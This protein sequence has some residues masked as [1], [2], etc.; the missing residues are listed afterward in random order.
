MRHQ[1]QFTGR[2]NRTI[3]TVAKEEGVKLV[4]GDA[5]TQQRAIVY[6]SQDQDAYE[7][8]L[9][10]KKR[11]GG[12]LIPLSVTSP[13]P[14]DPE[15]RRSRQSFEA[16]WFL[17]APIEVAMDAQDALA[18][19]D[20]LTVVA[21]MWGKRLA[22]P[23]TTFLERHRP[24]QARTDVYVLASDEHIAP[25]LYRD[26]CKNLPRGSRVSFHFSDDVNP[27]DLVVERFVGN[28]GYAGAPYFPGR[29]AQ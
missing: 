16:N 15:A 24:K 11:F 4:A 13:Y 3:K 12:I 8:A 22:A 7:E 6:L 2:S 19:A 5:R 20:V 10:I 1:I 25:V 9:H 23:L 29:A 28:T 14:S 17:A 27:L 18:T 26:I 21:S